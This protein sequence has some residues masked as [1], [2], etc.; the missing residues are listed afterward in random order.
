[1]SGDA[2]SQDPA[3]PRRWIDTTKAHPVRVYDVFPGGKDVAVG[4]KDAAVGGK[5]RGSG[6]PYPGR[7]PYPRPHR[8][9]L[10]VGST[11]IP[12]LRC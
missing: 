5:D 6:R 11:Y 4:G 1:M 3:E 9:N 12:R 2:L 8:G 7:C 10:L